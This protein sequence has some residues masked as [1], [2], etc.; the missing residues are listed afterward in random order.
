MKPVH[1]YVRDTWTECYICGLDFPTYEMVR[2][3]KSR[4]L[5]DRTCADA[6]GHQDYIEEMIIP[7]EHIEPSEQ[8]V[9]DQGQAA[10][11]SLQFLYDTG[12]YDSGFYP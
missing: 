7:A 9:S 6:K 3:Y 1:P 12:L 10:D 2:H 4:K 11:L 5:V 8:P